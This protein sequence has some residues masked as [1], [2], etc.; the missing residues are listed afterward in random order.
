MVLLKREELSRFSVRDA[1]GV[2]GRLYCEKCVRETEA[3]DLRKGKNALE[4]PHC[5]QAVQGRIKMRTN[6]SK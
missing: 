4:C 1:S 2:G 6:L 5:L 3:E